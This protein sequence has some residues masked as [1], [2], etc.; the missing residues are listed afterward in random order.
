MG[1]NFAPDE[2]AS[3]DKTLRFKPVSIKQ[4]NLIP[5][6]GLPELTDVQNQIKSLANSVYDRCSNKMKT[7]I[8]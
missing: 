1:D 5:P 7:I 2:I 4:F 8:K 6:P 3:I